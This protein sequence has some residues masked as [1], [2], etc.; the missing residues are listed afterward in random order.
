MI[1]IEQTQN[2]KRVVKKLHVQHKQMLD[3]A[4]K[5]LIGNPELGES[6][7]GDL[8]GIRVHEFEINHQKIKLAYSY[9]EEEK[10]IVLIALGQHENFYRD[11]KKH[12]KSK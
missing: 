11:L 1:R 8:R 10:K 12:L 6:K 3:K 7:V 2:F 9:F 4:I 5:D